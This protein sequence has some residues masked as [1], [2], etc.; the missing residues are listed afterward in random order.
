VAHGRYQIARYTPELERH[1]VRLLTHLWTGEPALNSAYFRWKYAENPYFADPLVHLALCDGQVVGMRGMCGARWQVGAPPGTFAAP[2]ADDLVVAPEHRNQGLFT[3]IMRAALD[4][5]AG[6]GLDYVVNLSAGRV[7][8]LGSLSMGWKSAGGVGPV[9]LRSQRVGVRQRVSA[10]LDRTQFLRRIASAPSLFVHAERR[11]PFARLDRTAARVRR[12]DGGA[13][14]LSKDARPEAMA[15][16]VARLPLDGRFR[17]VRDATYLAWRFRNPLREYRFLYTG[18]DRLDGYLVLQCQRGAHGRARV[19]VVD[20]EATDASIRDT[21]LDAALTGAFAEL[22]T[23]TA[24]LDADT[25]DLLR[26]RGF[27]PIDEA[28]AA[29]GVPGVLIR[30]VRDDALRTDWTIGG[31]RLLDLANWDLR[32]LYSMHG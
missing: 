25:R 27:T 29:R 11:G 15:D 32:M 3:R 17:H 8:S 16:L 14:S 2:Y 24:S 7:T 10:V 9:G 30:P 20:W 6:R 19:N 12:Y 26:R 31:R 21:L 23:W 13:V 18:D 22:V 28:D 1:L 4:E 5:L